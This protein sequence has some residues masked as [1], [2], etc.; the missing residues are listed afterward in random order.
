MR[1][2]HGR[3]C[4]AEHSAHVAGSVVRRDDHDH[5]NRIHGARAF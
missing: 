5:E 2:I 4:T 3:T 1:V